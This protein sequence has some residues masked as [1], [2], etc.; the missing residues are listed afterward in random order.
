MVSVC[1][2]IFFIKLPDSIIS[3]SFIII[4]GSNDNPTA[5]DFKR[6]YRKLLVCHEVVYDGK[7]ANCIS[8]ETGILTVSS[9]IVSGT[10][11]ESNE[12]PKP[13][14]INLKKLNFNYEE[15]I[16]EEL[17]KLDEHLNAYA[18]SKVEEKIKYT[19]QTQK[20]KCKK[21]LRVFHENEIISDDFITRKMLTNVQNQPCKSTVKIIKAI[22]KMHE[23]LPDKGYAAKAIIMTF[24]KN[25][26]HEDLFNGTEFADH[27]DPEMEAIEG[28][29]GTH[30]PHVVKVYINMKAHNIFR[31]ISDEERGVYI[32]HQNRKLTL[33][34]GQ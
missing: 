19:I 17:E 12:C 25:L 18:A 28:I 9:E 7:K 20:H 23:L 11:N 26:N 1:I 4:I 24:L 6:L 31:K 14:L 30:D 3:F 8:N 29:E 5:N 16:D 10:A 32:R 22:N 15:A 34:A 2:N 21:C 13:D 33:F 27:I